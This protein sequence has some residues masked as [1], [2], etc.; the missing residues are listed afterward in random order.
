[1]SK[2]SKLPKKTENSV[3]Y[4]RL[5]ARGAFTRLAMFFNARADQNFTGKEVAEILLKAIQDIRS[6][7]EK[8]SEGAEQS[9]QKGE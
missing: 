6:P 3:R 4:A 5:A 7:L 9:R 8:L 1:M 2:G